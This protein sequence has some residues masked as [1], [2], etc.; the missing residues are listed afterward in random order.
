MCAKAAASVGREAVFVVPFFFASVSFWSRL[1]GKKEM[2]ISTGES[3][4]IN[5]LCYLHKPEVI[6]FEAGYRE[7]THL[8]S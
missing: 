2:R 7:K 6:C 3:G 5:M 4:R 1:V 8:D